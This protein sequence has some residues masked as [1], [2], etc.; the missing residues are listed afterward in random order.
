M[1]K[2]IF[3]IV[4]GI[5]AAAVLFLAPSCT[6]PANRQPII[7][8]LEAEAE[9]ILPSRSLQVTC[10]ATDPDG[11]ALNYEWSTTGGDIF[12]TGASINWTAPEEAGAYNLT[13]VVKDGHGSSATDSLLIN[14]ATEQL[15]TIEA[16]LVTAE[17]C[18]LKTYSWGYKVG[19]EKEY[20]I[21][22]VVADTSIELVYDW[23][24]DA[25]EI[26][27]EG[28]MITWTAPN[29]SSST[30]VTVTVIVS[31]IVGNMA[32][33]NVILNVVECSTCTFGC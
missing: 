3:L 30:D 15:P 29:P 21:E 31:D 28:S 20:H 14:V 12:G 24:C 27:G 7:I 8:S 1:N 26:S 11:D 9:W 32:N 16:L 13:V 19:K 18:Y 22:C 10:N 25:G 2:R 6:T 17:H 33:K 4:V 23:S 5:V